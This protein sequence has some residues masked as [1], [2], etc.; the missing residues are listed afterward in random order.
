MDTRRVATTLTLCAVLVMGRLDTRAQTCELSVSGVNKNRKA[1]GPLDQ[2][3]S[4][5]RAPWG[6]WGVT[7]NY[8]HKRDA[9]QFE[10]WHWTDSK[11]QWNSC[12]FHE[13]APP[14]CNYYNYSNCTQQITYNP[15]AVNVHGT[16]GISLAVDCPHDTD[17]DGVCDAGGCSDV[18]SYSSGTNWMTVYELDDWFGG[19]DLVQSMYF[20]SLSVDLSCDV[21]G[22][23]SAGGNWVAPSYY[24]S[25]S[26]PAKIYAQMSMVVN[27]G[28]Y[29]D[30]A[31]CEDLAEYDPEYN[32][33]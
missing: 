24:D 19:D 20:P 9:D 6:N 25:P 30:D 31:Y 4:A 17:G 32:C 23:D 11:Y 15:S 10:G 2:E 5:P 28:W 3:C 18:W 7:S 13:Y 8:G 33:Y 21:W 12:T 29:V 1:Y 16:T 27:Y 26:W 14:N 22:C